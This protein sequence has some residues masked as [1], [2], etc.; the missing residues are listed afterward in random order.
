MIQIWRLES[1]TEAEQAI[2]LRVAHNRARI[3][4]YTPY[5]P[6]VICAFIGRPETRSGSCADRMLPSEFALATGWL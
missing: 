1:Q 2:T 6:R 5:S 4:G 3:D